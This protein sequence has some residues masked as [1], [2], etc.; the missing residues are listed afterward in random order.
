[1]VLGHVVGG[2]LGLLGAHQANRS[3]R[4]QAAANNQLSREF[5]QNQIQWRVQD[6]RKAGVHPSV[7]MGI[8]PIGPATSSPSFQNELAHLGQGIS[9]ATKSRQSPARS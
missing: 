5:A 1:M 9:N 8:S 2:A 6:A 4:R 3:A 7:A